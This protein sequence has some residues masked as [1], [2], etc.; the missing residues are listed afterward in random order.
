LALASLP[1]TAPPETLYELGP[2]LGAGSFGSCVLARDRRTGQE[3]AIKTLDLLRVRPASVAREHGV[4]QHIA[5]AAAAAAADAGAAAATAAATASA[6]ARAWRGSAAGG[7]PVLPFAI[8]PARAAFAV[9]DPARPLMTFDVPGIV[10]YRGT[11]RTQAPRAEACF[12]FEL[13]RGGELFALLIKR[14]ALP[15]PLVRRSLRPVV[16]ALAFLHRIGVVHRDLKPENLLL[17]ESVPDSTPLH[18][19]RDLQLKISDFGLAQLLDPRGDTRLLKTCGTWAYSAPEMNAAPASRRP[20]YGFAYDM[21][22]LGVVLYVM[23]SGAHPFDPVGN[24]DAADIKARIQNGDYSFQAPVWQRVSPLAINIVRRLLRVEQEHRMTAQQTLL[25]GWWAAATLAPSRAIVSGASAST[26][27]AAA[28]AAAAAVAEAAAAARAPGS[29]PLPEAALP[30][31]PGGLPP[32][33]PPAVPRRFKV[34]ATTVVA[35]ARF[36]A[37]ASRTA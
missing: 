17:K 15:E 24:L 14:G 9:A 10:S 19:L 16:E 35:A 34:V 11:L 1:L 37:S 22:S 26:S 2:P 32:S 3:V 30:S 5:A 13:M 4:L 33:P 21:W 20:G 31:S 28:A 27:A 8:P 12:V 23:L 7:S 6:L 29:L 36:A 25:H 18:E